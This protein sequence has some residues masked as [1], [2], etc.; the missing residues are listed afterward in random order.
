MKPQ[1]MQSE[2]SFMVRPGNNA[3]TMGRVT[4]VIDDISQSDT[5]VMVRGDAK[6]PPGFDDMSSQGGGNIRRVVIDDLS[7]QGS[8]LKKVRGFD[9]M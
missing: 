1:D 3:T 9:D 6:L 8:Y 5:S 4:Q 2:D 7:S